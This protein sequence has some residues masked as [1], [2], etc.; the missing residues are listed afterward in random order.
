MSYNKNF[1]LDIKDIELIENALHDKVSRLSKLRLTH[2]ESTI[3]PVSDLPRVKEIDQEIQELN[4]LLGRLHN[5]K[6]WYRP[7]SG[8]Y[9]S[10]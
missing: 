7:K 8:P 9:I 5:Q 10:G 1:E 6:S 4:E 2:V 3:K